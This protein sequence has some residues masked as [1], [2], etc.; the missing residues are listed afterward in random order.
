MRK[1]CALLLTLL[2]FALSPTAILAEV[3]DDQSGTLV[4]NAAGEDDS[5][6]LVS[7]TIPEFK[8]IPVYIAP[9]GSTVQDLS[10]LYLE[11]P[12]RVTA[13]DS[14]GNTY[15]LALTDYNFD[16]V[17]ASQAGSYYITARP[18]I[19]GYTLAEDVSLPTVD[20]WLSVQ[21]PGHPQLNCFYYSDGYYYFP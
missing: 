4:K 14:L 6:E 21:M 20:L 7:F 12:I 17:N 11:N 9:L 1:Y 18:D 16:G 5:I 15:D 8:E 10:D 13:C 3:R 19:T 2:L